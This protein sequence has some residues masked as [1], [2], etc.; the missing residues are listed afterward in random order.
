[1]RKSL[2]KTPPKTEAEIEKAK[3][4]FLKRLPKKKSP[5]LGP[6]LGDKRLHSSQAMLAKFIPTNREEIKE[7]HE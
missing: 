2:V 3:E 7:H 4:Q 1:M 5:E 6:T